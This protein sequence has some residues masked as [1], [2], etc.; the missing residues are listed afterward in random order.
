MPRKTDG[1]RADKAG[2]PERVQR[3]RGPRKSFHLEFKNPAQKVAWAAFE[4][5]DVL[6][7]LGP[8]GTGK[9]HLAVA[10]AVNEIL[11]R[12]KKR[13]ILTRPIVEAGESLGFLPGTFDEKVNPYMLPLFDCLGKLVG[14]EG[15]QR[16]VVDRCIEVAPLAYMRG[17]TFD[18]AICIFD[19]AQN[20]SMI[21]LKLFLTRFGEN[22][23][24]IVTG[25]PTQS[26]LPGSY[27][28]L[29]EV[30]N[31]LESVDGVGIVEFKE[32]SICRHPLV[33]KIIQKLG[34]GVE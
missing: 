32:N 29:S 28:A 5:H 25:D 27:V 10:F 12:R 15:P 1:D 18:D 19:E 7:L 8:A 16:E 2:K 24:I 17:R 13:I 20:A 30:V 34:G 22:S 33:G 4:Q 23:K 3:E 21:Q 9:S 14:W 11:A 26:D 6:F 31:K